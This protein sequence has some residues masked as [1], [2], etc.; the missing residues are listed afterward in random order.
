MYSSLGVGRV[1]EMEKDADKILANR[2]P[3]DCV[4]DHGQVQ[5]IC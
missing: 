2:V 3:S 1:T 5:F 4:T